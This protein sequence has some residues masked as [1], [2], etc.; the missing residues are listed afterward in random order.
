M[1]LSII[2]PIMTTSTTKTIMMMVE[3]AIASMKDT[4]W[5]KECKIQT[6][7]S[8]VSLPA[9]HMIIESTDYLPSHW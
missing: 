5:H 8:N 1:P 6:D 2:T 7:A 3:V 9:V 4:L